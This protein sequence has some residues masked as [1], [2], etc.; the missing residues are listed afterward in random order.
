MDISNKSRTH[1]IIK[2]HAFRFKK[3]FGQNFLTDGNI[4]RKIVDVAKLDKEVAV[5]E[6]G[7]GIGALTE[8]LARAS[9]KVVAY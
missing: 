8:H 9:K 1:A 4:L 2:K 5:I 7:P 3:K 6:V